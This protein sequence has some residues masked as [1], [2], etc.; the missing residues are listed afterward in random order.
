MYSSASQGIARMA[1]YRLRQVYN[2][3]ARLD[4]DYQGHRVRAMRDIG[5]AIRQLGHR[6]MG[7]SNMYASYNYNNNSRIGM[8]GNG[9]MGMRNRNDASVRRTN[10]MRMPQAMSDSRMRQGLMVLQGVDMYLMQH[11]MTPGHARSR[12]YIHLAM[13]EINTA[14]TIR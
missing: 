12:G 1:V 7:Y 14:L 6:S 9:N 13:Q 2:G 11:G 8:N 3:L 5:M 4:H 10:A